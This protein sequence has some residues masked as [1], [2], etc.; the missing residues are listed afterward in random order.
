MSKL[1][2]MKEFVDR[3]YLQEVNRQ[4]FHPLGLAM[5]V[6]IDDH[7]EVTFGGFLDNRD[8]P[9][10]MMFEPGTIDLVKVANIDYELATKVTKR[11]KRVGAIIQYPYN[12]NKESS[13]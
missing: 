12:T 11:M 1:L 2:D 9:E 10:G 4:F 3:G 13:K 8:D 6:E 5:V 7:G